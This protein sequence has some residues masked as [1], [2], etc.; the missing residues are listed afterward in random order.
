[1]EVKSAVTILVVFGI[2]DGS[3]AFQVDRWCLLMD[4]VFWPEGV[5]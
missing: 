4:Q 1:M 2:L 5:E 3:L